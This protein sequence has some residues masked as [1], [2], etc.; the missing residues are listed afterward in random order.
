MDDL[1]SRKTAVTH[2]KLLINLKPFQPG[3]ALHIETSLICTSNHM[4]GFYTK[5]DT[6]LKWVN[7]FHVNVT[8]LYK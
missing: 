6:G 8:F 2:S 4:T 5:G 1:K 7:L 3:V